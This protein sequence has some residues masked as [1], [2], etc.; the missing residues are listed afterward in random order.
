M[1]SSWIEGGTAVLLAAALVVS[2]L[3]SQ[4]RQEND[5]VLVK[6]RLDALE[7]RMKNSD[8]RM[9]QRM[10]N[11]D[12]RMEQRMKDSAERLEGWMKEGMVR[13]EQRMQA[14]EARLLR[15]LRRRRVKP[16]KLQ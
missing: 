4:G 8:E 1:A 10:K 16:R 5:L 15:E 3:I 7:Q 6:E 14:T 12:E 13:M 2:A 11:S 9:E